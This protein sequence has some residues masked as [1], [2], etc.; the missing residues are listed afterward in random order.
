MPNHLSTRQV[1]ELVA[2]QLAPNELTTVIWHLA[3]CLT[4][5]ANVNLAHQTED[6]L[7]ALPALLQDDLDVEGDHLSYEQLSGFADHSQTE[8]ERTEVNNHL[9]VCNDCLARAR[10]LEEIW[11]HIRPANDPSSNSVMELRAGQMAR[12]RYWNSATTWTGLSV[13]AIFF[14]TAIFVFGWWRKAHSPSQRETSTANSAPAL[15]PKVGLPR[16]SSAVPYSFEPRLALMDHGRRVGLDAQGNLMGFIPLTASYAQ[17]I[18]STLEKQRPPV[19]PAFTELNPG[20]GALLGRNNDAGSFS[21]WSPVGTVVMTDRPT[22]RWQEMA[23]A[24][25]YSVAILD[26]NSNLVAQSDLL[27]HPS[28]T[29]AKALPR[30]QL[31]LWQVTATRGNTRITSPAPPRPEARFK[32]LTRAKAMELKQMAYQYAN[33]HLLLGVRYSQAG[34]LA[35]AE[36]EFRALLAE[37]PDSRL[38]EKLLRSAQRNRRRN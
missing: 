22:F 19:F 10:E 37:N 21:L 1:S 20:P 30:D 24:E 18:K 3:E 7:S 14:V 9:R 36:R 32:I 12:Y 33:S 29:P 15:A 35:E 4:C 6:R 8:D 11:A 25:S 16:A 5:R 28:W 31:L 2:R 13:A 26:R 17:I 27:L 23:M 34:L 38:V